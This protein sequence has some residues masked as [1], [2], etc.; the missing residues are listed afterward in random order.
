MATFGRRGISFGNSAS[1]WS[2]YDDN[3]EISGSSSYH[4]TLWKKIMQRIHDTNKF[5]SVPFEMP[6]SVTQRTICSQTGLLASSDACTKLTEYF[7]EGT[8]P[9]KSCPGHAPAATPDGSTP[10]SGTTTEGGTTTTT[11]ATTP[12][13]TQ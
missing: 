6:E 11:P 8:V 4:K 5:K 13:P 2:G 7:A 3:Q 9:K 12:A 1:V 10:A